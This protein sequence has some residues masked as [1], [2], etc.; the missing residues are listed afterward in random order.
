MTR[1]SKRISV[2]GKP[3]PDSLSRKEEEKMKSSKDYKRNEKSKT[4][5][6]LQN[7]A[8]ISLLFMYFTVWMTG[9][10]IFT[11]DQYVLIALIGTTTSTTI[12]HIMKNLSKY[13]RK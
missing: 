5:K 6:W 2:R 4:R 7:Y 10:S 12:V 3:K 13:V 8:T 1:K 11:I 9:L